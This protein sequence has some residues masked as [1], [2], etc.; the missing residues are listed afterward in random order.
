[1]ARRVQS[2]RPSEIREIL[3]LTQ[4]PGVISFAGGLPAPE[5]FPAKELAEVTRE[6]LEKE[7]TSA[8]Q[9]A[10]TEGF[11]PLRGAVA[12]RMNA[13]RGARV[14]PEEILITS[15]SQQGLD[16]AGKVFLDPGDVLLCESPTY[17]GAI[18]AFRAYEPR[19]VEVATDDEGMVPEALEKAIEEERPK[20]VYAIPDFQNPSGRCWSMDRRRAFM[21]IVSRRGVP[22]LEDCPYA[23]LRF[24][25][26]DLPSLK[27]MDDQGL[28]IFLGTFSKVFCPGLRVGWMAAASELLRRFIIAKQGADLHTSSLC[29]RQVEG[30]LRLFDMDAN[31]ARIR[32]TYRARRDAMLGAMDRDFPEGLRYTRPEGG[33][34]LWVEMREGLDAR[35]VL[36]KALEK[37]VAFIPGAPFFPCGGHENTFRLNYATMDGPRIEEGIGRLAAVLREF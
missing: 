22:V 24:E 12:Q 26:K 27:S 36:E 29:Q 15:G 20:F 19:F 32:E 18:N 10:P 1:M 8:L 30:Y 17:I 3:K 5:L 6:I 25:G 21:E 11:A 28:V 23:E 37:D 16:F 13:L 2:M 9:Y 7:G 33:F 4:K 34:F 31:I 35:A 14:A